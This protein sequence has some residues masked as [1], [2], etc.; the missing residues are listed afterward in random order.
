MYNNQKG[1]FLY[2]LQNKWLLVC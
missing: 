1:Y 2:F